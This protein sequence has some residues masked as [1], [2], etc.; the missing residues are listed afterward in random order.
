MRSVQEVENVSPAS[1]SVVLF[2][3]VSY[4]SY[5]SLCD[6]LMSVFRLPPAAGVDVSK[7]PDKWYCNMM[8]EYDL[9]LPWTCSVE[10]KDPVWYH[11]HFKTS[12]EKPA[13]GAMNGKAKAGILLSPSADRKSGGGMSEEETK[14]LV[15]R[16]DILK[17]L[18]EIKM[19]DKS[20]VTKHYFHEAL[21]TEKDAA[22]IKGSSHNVKPRLKR[23]TP[24]LL[25][26]KSPGKK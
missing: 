24:K 25:S 11:T 8:D 1:I 21:L 2:H 26:K 17:D 12:N 4:Y 14:K 10:E 3:Y 15:E 6:K 23:V 22:A 13:L 7:L 5:F 19:N 16:D 9:R 20:I 18:L